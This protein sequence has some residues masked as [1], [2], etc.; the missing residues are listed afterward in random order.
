MSNPTLPQGKTTAISNIVNIH[1]SNVGNLTVPAKDA[2]PKP[3]QSVSSFKNST[4]NFTVTQQYVDVKES[5]VRK[6]KVILHCH[7]FPGTGKSEIMRKLAEE[8]PYESNH[9]LY[10]KWHI[11]FE[12][13]GHDAQAQLQELV[14]S[15][16]HSN[17]ITED[18]KQRVI[19]DLQRNC[20]GSLAELLRE[21]KI[22]VLII[23]E[24][25]PLKTPKLLSDLLRSV[26]KIQEN[27]VPFHVYMATRYQTVLEN[28]ESKKISS[29]RS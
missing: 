23:F 17:L 16:F 19:S 15:L 6:E 10:I 7:G 28:V 13:E 22:S 26:D 8:F 20:A 21:T 2:E 25:V 3:K 11:E 14:K 9:E 18:A 24:D 1:N 12:D 27:N 29:Y 5:V 4:R